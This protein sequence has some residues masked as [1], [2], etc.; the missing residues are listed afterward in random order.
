[1]KTYLC[2]FGLAVMLGWATSVGL[3]QVENSSRPSAAPRTTPSTAQTLSGSHEREEAYRANNMGVALLEQFNHREGAEAF[4]RAL[5]VDPRLS[6]ARINL[7]IALYNLPDI[8]N[9]LSE[10]QEAVRL[11]P[12]APQPHYI[13]G[14]I[15]RAQNRSED[16]I[17]AFHRVLEI[18]EQDVGA[19]IQLGQLYVQARRYAEAVTHFRAALTAEPYNM[20]A[21]YN[22]AN[23]LARTGAREESAQLL[24]RFQELR[25]SGAGTTI[26]QNYLEQGRYAEAVTSTGAEME[27]VNVRT[28]DVAFNNATAN[29]LPSVAVSERRARPSRS[30]PGSSQTERRNS[31]FNRTYRNADLNE[32]DRREI[33]ASFRGGATLFDFDL[34]GDLDIFDLSP[35]GERL[36][37]NDGGRFVDVTTRAGALGARTN[38]VSIGAVAGDYDN[39]TKPD[40]FVLRYGGRSALYHNDGNGSFSDHTAMTNIPAFAHLSVS[41]ALVDADHDGDLDLFIAGFTDFSRRTAPRAG[42]TNVSSASGQRHT[43]ISFP[44]DFNGAPNILMRNNGDGTF[45]NITEAARVGGTHHQ[46]AI[47]VVPTDYDNRRD[48]DLLIAH[49]NAPPALFR[50][51]RDGTFRDVASETGLASVERATCA[52]AGDFNKDNFTDFYFGSSEAPGVFAIS[53]A[54]GHFRIEPTPTVPENITN[55]QFTEHDAAQFLDYDN[56]GLLDLV[57]ISTSGSSGAVQVWRNAGQNGW[58]NVSDRAVSTNLL[59]D[60]RGN[61]RQSPQPRSLAS[62]D[63][64]RDGD[65]DLILRSMSGELRFARNDGGNR[66]R[67]VRVQLTGRV[68][69]RGGVGAKVDMRAGSLR[70][71]IETYAAS[72]APAPSDVVFGLGV[73][74]A[75]DAVRVIWPAGIVQ[76]ETEIA[77][78]G[79]PVG[80][81]AST[82]LNV[83]ITELDR[84]P[85][86]CPYLFTWNGQAFE[87]IT[88]MMGGGEMGYTFAPGARNYPDPD[89][90]VRIRADQLRERNGRFE[91]RV[92]NELEEALFVDRMQLVAVS[93]PREVEIYPN[94]GLGNPTA[95]QFTLYATRG[96]R[97]A[98]SATD[99][100]G[101]D[102]SSNLAHVDRRFADNFPLTGIRGYAVPHTLTLDLGAEAQ[103]AHR[104]LLLMTGWTDYA[105]SSDNIAA[106]QRGLSLMPPALQVRN[107]RGEW[108]TVIENIGIPVGRPQTVAV[109]LTGKFLSRTNREVRIVTNMRIYWDQILVDVSEENSQREMVRLDPL[110]ATL[111]WRGFSHETS[112][113]GR[114]PF[115]YDYAR[116]SFDSPWKLMSG[117]YTREGDV[118]ELLLTTDDM[119]VISRSGDEIAV[120]FDATRLPPLPSGWT[121]TFLLYIDGYSKEMDINSASPDQVWPLPFHGMSRYPYRAPEEYPMTPERRAYIERYN[122]RIVR[123]ELPSIESAILNARRTASGAIESRSSERESR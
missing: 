81:S 60:A 101:R 51:L 58:T 123:N 13:L 88:D 48:V 92:T 85:S 71:K 98:A 65:T 14:L 9:A 50:N 28:P 102:L 39:D 31:I 66:N 105:F 77:G 106:A 70:Q 72:P 120:E 89:E 80:N 82:A 47:A 73:R 104:V 26:G 57:T 95:N 35:S 114:E 30:A 83:S 99:D 1:M 42:G 41:A 36:L 43:T 18:D 21:V 61:I 94:E 62:G 2:L 53:D 96:A 119:F 90:Y 91:I 3:P 22:L 52:A 110:A 44:S 67:S 33:A 76:A 16:A 64:D 118:R 56:D 74:T 6:I 55:A 11:A 54:R 78:Q 12:R 111:R 97:P 109:D 113:D 112:P 84:R 38:G 63:V 86:S 46:Q 20:T 15:S 49:A 100:Q 4:R 17:A 79:R 75:P 115:G 10:A 40:L 37:R 32:A 5:R 103:S 24:R 107:E 93:H 25:Q 122:T 87:F 29:V 69:N 8:E 34:D 59:A 7:A 121:R 68:S 19:N 23:A 45:A 108:Q 27:L 117:R 116:V